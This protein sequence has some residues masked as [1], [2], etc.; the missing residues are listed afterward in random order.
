M[1]I[2]GAPFNERLAYDYDDKHRV[3]VREP[4][5]A[6]DSVNDDQNTCPLS[7]KSVLQNPPLQEWC[8][9]PLSNV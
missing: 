5:S 1:Q 4:T 7:S 9:T 6:G 8:F 2:T 3:C